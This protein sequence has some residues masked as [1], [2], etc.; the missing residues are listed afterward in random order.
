MFASYSV[1]PRRGLVK[2]TQSARNLSTKKNMSIEDKI[3][4]LG[5]VLPGVPLAPKGNYMSYTITGKYVYLAGHLPQPAEGDLVKGRLG[6]NMTI[7]QGAAAARLCALQMI[8]SM[9]AATDGDLTKIKKIVK[10]VGFVSS[11]NDFTD[12]PKVL[13]GCSDLMGAVFGV[14]VGRHARSALGVNVL[15]LG[16]PV[17]I[18]AIVELH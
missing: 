14:E 9:K 18:E 15:P 17:E 6:E 10:V 12:Q 7:E 13:N 3:R 4:E 16:V 8:A 2:L 1:L 11:T 5:H